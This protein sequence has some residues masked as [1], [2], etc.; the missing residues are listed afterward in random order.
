VIIYVPKI[1]DNY[2]LILQ[3]SI[4]IWFNNY[5]GYALKKLG[6]RCKRLLVLVFKS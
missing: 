3:C 5:M 6:V 4:I 2:E 1:K